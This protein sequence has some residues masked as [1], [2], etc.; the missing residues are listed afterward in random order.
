VIEITMTTPDALAA[1]RDISQAFGDKLYAA[2]GTVLDVATARE[3]ILAGG[4]L[5]VSPVILPEVVALA[6]RYGAACYP[7]AS[8]ATECLLA[9]QAGADMVK[10]FPAQIGGP[11]YMTNLRMVFP[12]VNLIPSGGI[13]ERN[14]ADYIRCGACAVSGA[15]TFMNHEMIAQEGVGWITGQVRRYIEIVRKAKENLP[16][17]P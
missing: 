11:S 10:I 6:H 5:I 17:L 3:V 9:M 7:G 4:K 14:A 8:T 13:T 2:A 16:P 15:R 1:I 12:D